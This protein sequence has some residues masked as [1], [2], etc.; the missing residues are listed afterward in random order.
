VFGAVR[1]LGIAVR[2]GGLAAFTRT[3]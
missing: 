2:V 3:G 1:C